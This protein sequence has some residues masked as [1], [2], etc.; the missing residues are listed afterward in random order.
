MKKI[1]FYSPYTTLFK[2]CRLSSISRIHVTTVFNSVVVHQ[3][4]KHVCKAINFTRLLFAKLHLI[5]KLIMY[6]VVLI[7]E[8]DNNASSLGRRL[9]LL[10]IHN[11]I[12]FNIM[13]QFGFHARISFEWRLHRFSR[14]IREIFY[15]FWDWSKRKYNTW[16]LT[17]AKKGKHFRTFM[18]FNLYKIQLLKNR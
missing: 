3:H 9:D 4:F 16:S 8:L 15:L 17:A 10:F 18:I 13:R 1:P 2:M 5:L 6:V 14:Q 12:P 7:Q 11:F